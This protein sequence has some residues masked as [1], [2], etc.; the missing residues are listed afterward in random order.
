M[1]SE[2]RTLDL[3]AAGKV[4]CDRARADASAAHL[5]DALA[6][7]AIIVLRAAN[8]NRRATDPV[9]EEIVKLA[10]EA[11]EEINAARRVA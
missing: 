10:Q 3:M 4:S 8:E 6:A 2:K 1:P 9:L 11:T 7:L 5:D